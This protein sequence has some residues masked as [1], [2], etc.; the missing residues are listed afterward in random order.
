MKFRAELDVSA[1]INHI[2][3]SE[4]LTYIYPFSLFKYGRLLPG[5]LQAL[6]V[7]ANI[8][9]IVLIVGLI[10]MVVF[11]ALVR[12]Y[13]LPPCALPEVGVLNLVGTSGSENS[14]LL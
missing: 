2:A 14:H 12:F 13:Y 5:Y 8:P 7:D 9:M 6:G 1:I 4:I 10:P 3:L 11:N